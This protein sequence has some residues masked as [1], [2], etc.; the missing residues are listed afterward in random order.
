MC[1]YDCLECPE[2]DCNCPDCPVVDLD[3]YM[4][5]G[6]DDIINREPACF[7]LG[8]VP[9]SGSVPGLSSSLEPELSEWCASHGV[10]PRVDADVGILRRAMNGGFTG[11]KLEK[12]LY[13]VRH[14]DKY[15]AS[16]KRCAA[17]GS[18]RQRPEKSF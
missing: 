6:L 4:Q 8:S 5:F 10:V 7:F 13:K 3:E 16:K 9:G 14:R 15:L 12:A 11:K 1:D 2:P 17:R 18:G